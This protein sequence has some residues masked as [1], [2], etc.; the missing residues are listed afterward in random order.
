MSLK[1]RR[2]REQWGPGHP[3]GFT[4]VRN[5]LGW[6]GPQAGANTWGRWALSFWADSHGSHFLWGLL[7]VGIRRTPSLLPFLGCC[8]CTRVC[9]GAPPAAGSPNDP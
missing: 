3:E 8:L 5:K 1:S 9:G 6:E 4:E 7:G 2:L